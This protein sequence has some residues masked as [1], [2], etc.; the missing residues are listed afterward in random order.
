MA[1]ATGHDDGAENIAYQIW[2]G[3]IVTVVAATI[4]VVLRFIS[5]SIAKAGFWWDDWVIVASLIVNWAMAITRWIQVLKFHFGDHAQDIPLQDIVDYQQSFMAIQLVYFTNAVLTKSSLL[6]LYQRIFGV[7]QRFRYA[8]FTSWFLIISYFIAC[9]I[10]SIFSCIP[11]SYLWDRFAGPDPNENNNAPGSCFNEVAFFRWNGIAN[12]LLDVLMLVLPLPMVWH[13]CTSLR[14]KVLLT[15][16]FGMGGFVC[17]VSLLRIISFDSA[18]RT[19]PTYTQIPS[20]TWSSV[21]QGTGIVC[22]CLPT[23]RPLRRLFSS[24]YSRNSWKTGSSS[25]GPSSPSSNSNSNLKRSSGVPGAEQDVERVGAGFG[26]GGTTVLGRWAEG[27]EDLLETMRV[28]VG[29]GRR[30]LAGVD[31]SGGFKDHGDENV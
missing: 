16:I 26:F 21:E 8:L 18:D 31:S 23:L 11:V 13:M 29:E 20:S 24:R 30:S 19:D 1:H 9:V 10:A 4:A 15:G 22:A 6:L 27:D 14:Q 3:T 12:M 2:V 5:R 25:Q 7:V 28:G 17:I